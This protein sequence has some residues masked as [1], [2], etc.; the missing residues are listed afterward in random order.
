MHEAA[1]LCDKCAEEFAAGFLEYGERESRVLARA[2]TECAA[3]LRLRSEAIPPDETPV[4]ACIRR[5]C[6]AHRGGLWASVEALLRLQDG[7]E[8][9]TKRLELEHG[10]CLELVRILTGV[11][12]AFEKDG[13][14]LKSDQR[15]ALID[16][17]RAIGALPRDGGGPV[18]TSTTGASK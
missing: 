7:I 3:A 12:M 14:R 9:A 8:R 10:W 6:V 2:A 11:V 5:D 16:A 15:A 4:G 17:R 18:A 13:A 1:E